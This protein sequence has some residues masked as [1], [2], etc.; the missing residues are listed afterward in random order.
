MEDSKLEEGVDVEVLTDSG[1]D[2]LSDRAASVFI[3]LP[4]HS[5][6]S[7]R[8]DLYFVLVLRSTISM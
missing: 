4:P 7:A 5:V 6:V 2:S 3:I 1:P 8:L